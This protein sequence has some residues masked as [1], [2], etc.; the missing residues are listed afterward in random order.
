MKISLYKSG[1]LQSPVIANAWAAKNGTYKWRVPVNQ[2]LST[3]YTIKV[4]AIGASVSNTSRTFAITTKPA[5]NYG[6]LQINTVDE[7]GTALTGAA[8]ILDETPTGFLIPSFS[9]M[10]LL[11]VFTM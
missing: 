9:P 4:E 6:S 2:A 3:A 10:S 11:L 1:V 5:T 8:I 7:T